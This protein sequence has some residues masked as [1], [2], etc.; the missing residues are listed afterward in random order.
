MHGRTRA[1]KRLAITAAAAC[2]IVAL[3]V[4]F[5]CIPDLDT[6]PLPLVDAGIDAPS[7]NGSFCGDGVIDLARGEECDPGSGSD[8]FATCSSCK[9][10]CDPSH[11]NPANHHCYFET[12]ATGDYGSAGDQCSAVGAHVA[13][14]ASDGTPVAA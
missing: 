9:L 4:A 5:S 12:E 6:T 1:M 10:A 14:F 13:T 3:A 2:A 11:V 8:P 7:T